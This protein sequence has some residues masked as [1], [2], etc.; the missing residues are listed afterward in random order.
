MAECCAANKNI[1]NACKGERNTA[2]EVTK[3]YIAC[4]DAVTSIPADVD[5]VVSSDIVLADGEAFFQWDIDKVG[6]SW[7]ITTEGDG[8][9]KQFLF[10]GIYRITGIAAAVSASLDGLIKGNS[11]FMQ[12]DKNDLVQIIGAVDDGANVSIEAQNDPNG[13]IVTVTWRS[14]HMPYFYTGTIEVAPDA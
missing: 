3:I 6:S 10:T 8:Q 2:T 7:K 5:H 13:Y 4:E 14:F 11:I 9:A 1:K 12:K